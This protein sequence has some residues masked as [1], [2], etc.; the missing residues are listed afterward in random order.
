MSSAIEAKE[1]AADDGLIW[2]A[3][4]NEEV[5][6][7]EVFLPTL[8]RLYRV[9][10]D[11]EI[12]PYYSFRVE[13]SGRDARYAGAVGREQG[14]NVPGWARRWP[15]TATRDARGARQ[16]SVAGC[17]RRRPGRAGGNS[18]AAGPTP[19][20]PCSWPSWP[21]RPWASRS[22]RRSRRSCRTSYRLERRADR[23]AD[24][25]V[26]SG[27]GA[28]RDPHGA[29]VGEV[30]RPR[31]CSRP[32]PSSWPAASC[33]AAADS[34]AVVAR[35]PLHPGP[36]RRRRHARGHGAD[37]SR[38][39]APRLA[40]PGVRAVRRR[41]RGWARSAR[42]WSCPA[43]PRPAATAPCSSRRRSSASRSRARRGLT[44]RAEV[45]AGTWRRRPERARACCARSGEAAQKRQRPARSPS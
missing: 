36:G 41:H 31:R 13:G 12:C 16:D 9:I 24:L 26:R 2:A 44:A 23:S 1:N 30:G 19:S 7:W 17:R 45:A 39:V 37:H 6:N 15:T 27:R 40:P 43:W 29:R 4:A 3:H 11:P 33:F 25:G 42:C 20:P 5:G 28:R 8:M 32:P 38:L 14:R 21:C 34:Y 18:A 35:G 10:T 22:S